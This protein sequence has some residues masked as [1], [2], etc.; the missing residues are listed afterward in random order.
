MSNKTLQNEVRRMTSDSYTPA[1]VARI[2]RVSRAYV[3][4][5]MHN[6]QLPYFDYGSGSRILPR[7]SEADLAEFK[8]RRHSSARGA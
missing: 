8:Q 4:M 3:Y 5:L 7:I 1:E 6:K 2:L